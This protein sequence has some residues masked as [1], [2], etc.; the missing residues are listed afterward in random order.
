MGS[1]VGAGTTLNMLYHSK[2]MNFRQ[3]QQ[4]ILPEEMLWRVTG[5]NAQILGLEG[6]IGSL[7]PGCQADMLFFS[8]PYGFAIGADSLSQLC[9]L[10]E[11]FCLR[12]V[13]VK[14][15]GKYHSEGSNA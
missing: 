6:R 10:S 11:D 12:E 9:F 14:G 1:D 5:A 4:P 8:P 15:L 3:S 13:L 2:Q 7:S